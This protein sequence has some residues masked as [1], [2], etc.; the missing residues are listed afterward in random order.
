MMKTKQSRILLKNLAQNAIWLFDAVVVLLLLI[1]YPD[2]AIWIIPTGIII[3][4][5]TLW[6]FD[7]LLWNVEM[8]IGSEK[9]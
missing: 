9:D 4:V 3:F 6:G 7:E 1:K 5:V 8:R 2:D